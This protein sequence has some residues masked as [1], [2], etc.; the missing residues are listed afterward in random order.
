MYRLQKDLEAL[1]AT[2]LDPDQLLSTSLVEALVE[3][4][5]RDRVAVTLYFNRA[6]LCVQS[7]QGDE[8]VATRH[9]R[10]RT[11]NRLSGIRG[12]RVLPPN[13]P[14]CRGR[15]QLEVGRLHLDCMVVV[16][17]DGGCRLLTPRILDGAPSQEADA[18]EL[19]RVGELASRSLSEVLDPLESA[20]GRLRTLEAPA[21]R[22]PRAL[23]LGIEFTGRAF[24]ALGGASLDELARLAETAGVEPGP[25]LSQRRAAPRPGTFFGRGK[26]DEVRARILDEGYD[27]VLCGCDLPYTTVSRLAELLG[28]RVLDRSELIL[29]IFARH[30]HTNEGR[31]QVKLARFEHELHRL[32]KEG[33]D[34]DRNA[35]GVG[36]RSGPGEAAAKLL[37]RRVFRKKVVIE[38]RLERVRKRRQAVRQRRAAGSA[39]RVSLAGYTNAGKS[40]LLNTLAGRQ[41]V[42]AADQLFTTLETTTRRIVMPGGRH[43]LWTDTVGFV[44]NLPHHLVAAF[45]ATLAEA[46]DADLTLVVLEGDL[47]EL[48]R[49]RRVVSEVLDQLGSDPSRRLEVVSKVDRLDVAARE[50]LAA[51]LPGA[52]LLSSH[53]GEGIEELLA[54]V[55]ARLEDQEHEV[56]LLVPF[57]RLAAV[58]PLFRS[59]RV[60]S[61]EWC[62]Q[63]MRLVARLPRGRLGEVEGFLLAGTA[64]P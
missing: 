38:E 57:A 1:E 50:E 63:G 48:D 21:G 19:T 56:E 45:E 5:R 39:A 7:C 62:D 8:T 26:L 29:E 40:T 3:L 43:V 55:A 30:A 16:A 49:H 17:C 51:R 14:L 4:A 59:G 20:L 6:G 31:L 25:R 12:V 22:R 32:M 34:L 11:T 33:R 42:V 54:R 64:A 18:E 52:L 2:R 10:R 28:R 58:D 41:V 13:A 15:D 37:Q 44:E 61:Q 35:G 53:S 27:L 24:A 60:V 46:A 9:L 23:L 36:V 47:A